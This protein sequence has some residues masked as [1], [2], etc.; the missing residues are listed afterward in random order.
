VRPDP[1]PRRPVLVF[2]VLGTLVDQAGGLEEQV[3]T[4]AG[5]ERDRATR[6]VEL[7]LGYV[8]AQERAIVAGQRQ[9]APSHVLDHEALESLVEDG[10]LP[11]KSVEA[12]GRASEQLMPWPDTRDGLEALSHRSTV[13]GLSNASR[14]VLAA[15]S[16]NGRL[17]W[18]QALSA[19]DANTYKPDPVLYR[20]AIS[21]TPAGSDPPIMVAAHAWDLRAAAA[22]GMRTAYVPRLNGDAPRADDE[23]DIMATSLDDLRAQLSL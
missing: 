20:T 23:F 14:R 1:D 12:L 15:V 4:V 17:R 5:L 10:S 22:A 2:D 8:A 11:D 9:F 13:V 19:E 18:H 7:W 3:A 21:A 16:A 6:I